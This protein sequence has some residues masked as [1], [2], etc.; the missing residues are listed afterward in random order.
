MLKDLCPTDSKQ[1]WLTA[2]CLQP[3]RKDIA[4]GRGHGRLLS[5]FS[6]YHTST[7]GKR[8]RE[9]N[10]SRL[11]PHSRG[12]RRALEW[13]DKEIPIKRLPAKYIS[14]KGN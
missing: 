11:L 12:S 8:V 14:N 5:A 6:V 4:G 13:I 9:E 2:V 7:A 3:A 10:R 1:A